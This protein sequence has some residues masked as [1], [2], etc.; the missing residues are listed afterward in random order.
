MRLLGG[1]EAQHSVEALRAEGAAS[2]PAVAVDP[3]ALIDQKPAVVAIATPERAVLI[4]GP[5]GAEAMRALAPGPVAAYDA[6]K[7]DHALH[8]GYGHGLPRWA[9]L[10][11][12]E[13]LLAGGRDWSLKPATMAARWHLA[14]PPDP[15]TGLEA[16]GLWAQWVAAAVARQIPELNRQELGRVSRVEAAAVAPIAA[17]ERHGL[18][19]DVDG[20]RRLHTQTRDEQRTLGQEIASMLGAS[21][22]L[23]G[24]TH[25]L[26]ANDQA[27]KHALH[28]QGHAVANVRRQTL[29][30]L[31]DPLGGALVRY[32]ELHKRIT[33]YG[34]AFL[35]HVGPDGR[36]HPTFEQ[37]GAS[38]GRMACREPNLQ[39]IV[40]DTA[41]RRCFH[42]PP[43]KTLVIAD[44]ATCEL[45]ILAEMSR[46]PVFANAFAAGDD[47]HARVAQAV[48]KQPVS[49]TE[50]PELRQRAKVINFGLVYGMGAQALANT[51]HTSVD[52]ARALLRTYFQTFPKIGAYLKDE[53]QAS[54]RR[55][56][57]TTLWGRRLYLDT[58]DRATAE[59]VARNMPIQGTSADITKIALAEVHRRLSGTSTT[60]I[61]NA[62]H[63]EIVVECPE[64]DADDVTVL[65]T[66]AMREAGE[67]VLTATPVQV[68][69]HVSRWWGKT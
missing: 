11:V 59:R 7:H 46:D 17:M 50:N 57:A 55:G 15:S 35:Q 61:V 26:L 38:T 13:Q 19:L 44:Y 8:R 29:A 20:W 66:Q 33:S 47:L 56:F 28:Q 12:T 48:F 51:T 58:N 32:R 68:D 65:V 27:L 22:D 3:A 45:R 9:C 16:L 31:P 24:D 60:T 67:A 30:Q 64:D 10:K 62:V 49:K 25:D 42:A 43:G 23:F 4:D 52:E 6:K 34:E 5:A 1:L 14:P 41:H 69:A 63:D 2:V 40:N 21:G 18:R 54:L 36:V 53:A 39:A 37:I